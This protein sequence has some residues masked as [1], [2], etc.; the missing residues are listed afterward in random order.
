MRIFKPTAAA[1]AAAML[2]LA[3]AG[4]YAVRGAG[5]HA[6]RRT[7]SPS[8]GCK[9]SVN[10]APRYVENGESAE[11]F[12]QLS[13]NGGTSV[14]NQTVTVMERLA[15]SAATSAGTATT[16][17]AGHYEL[18]SPALTVDTS[19]YTTALGAQSGTKTV[20]VS[21]KVTL[22]GPPE[23]AELFTGRGPIVPSAHKAA[24]RNT[25]TFTGS[26][27]P[28]DAGAFMALQREEANSGEL[29]RRIGTGTVGAG[30]S[31]TIVHTFSVPGDASIRVVVRPGRRDL[32]GPG[33]SETISYEISQ[34]QNPALTIVSSAEPIS[35]GQPVTISGTVA[36]GVGTPLTLLQRLRGEKNFV[37]VAKTTS[38]SGGA[39]A[40][41]AQTP[42]Q[43]VFYQVMGAGKT[44]AVLFEGV[45]YGLAAPAP[46]SAAQA[47][48]PLTF[49]GTVTPAQ[50]GHVVYLQVA[51]PSG[52]GMHTV[53]VG[54][55]NSTGAFS[56]VHS[57][58]VPGVKRFRVKVPGEPE[59][60]SIAS[61]PFT[62]NI[63]PAPPAALTPELP[64]NSSLPSEGQT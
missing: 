42:S 18:T 48:Q 27:S 34:S 22:A 28:A 54:T 63:A 26:V 60:E 9:L 20:R 8:G 1:I 58:Y 33:V 35:Y 57:Q 62:V 11:V 40:F 51:N 4:A 13:C 7:A 5:R 23:G 21:P 25:V 55:E 49:T 41:A 37:A 19:F 46:A 29:W 14:A 2:A 44:S 38:A 6:G 50:P 61:S 36:G 59:Y 24:Y 3:P 10:A 52:I 64:G 16:D 39:Y 17:S 56:I 12:G 53:E 32:N 45:K 43:S 47:G 15:G 31:F 30:G